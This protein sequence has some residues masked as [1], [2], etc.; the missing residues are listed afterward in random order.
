M[1]TSSFEK[2]PETPT[3]DILKFRQATWDFPPPLPGRASVLGI[4]DRL[5]CSLHL[6]FFF[7]LKAKPHTM[8]NENTIN[9]IRLLVII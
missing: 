2:H 4:T 7:K 5:T 3:Q 6:P 9:R 1:A 8:V